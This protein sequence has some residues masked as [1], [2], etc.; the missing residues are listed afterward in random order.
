M[1]LEKGKNCFYKNSLPSSTT[2]SLFCFTM[3]TEKKFW[4]LL[5]VTSFIK[6]LYLSAPNL[7]PQ[8]AYYWSWTQFLDWSYFDHPPLATWSMVPFTRV[9]GD[10]VFWIRFPVWIYGILDAVAILWISRIVLKKTSPALWTLAIFNV[11]PLF[12]IGSI[13]MTPDVPLIFF[14]AATVYCF[15]RAL[16]EASLRSWVLTGVALGFA[17]LGKYSGILL[18]PSAL[19]FLALSPKD[20]HWLL[21]PQP[22]AGLLAAFVVFLPVVYWNASHEWVSLAFQSTRRAQ[23]MVS[24][25]PETVGQFLGGQIGVANPVLFCCFLFSMAYVSWKKLYVNDRSIALLYSFSVVPF[26]VCLFMSFFSFVKM[27]WPAPAYLTGFL[28][29]A[30]L[31]EQRINW[32][33][34]MLMGVGIG[35]LFAFMTLLLPARPIVPF[36]GDTWT[37]WPQLTQY[38]WDVKAKM[39]KEHGIPVFVFGNEYKVSVEMW[40][41]NPKQERTYSKNVLGEK[42]LQFD[43]YPSPD[44]LVGTNAVFVWWD[45]EPSHHSEL[46]ERHFR[47]VEKE[48]AFEVEFEGIVFQKYH[49]YRCYHYKGPMLPSPAS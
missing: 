34:W 12:L 30:H 5:A 37:G 22:Y 31:F 29:T 2:I 11:A 38:V 28:L 49:I 32:R 19:L 8:E 15:Y 46:L 33:R 23:G 39:E 35:V 27:N 20:R 43:Y 14:W 47:K 6:L 4:I 36:K 1:F 3:T 26:A 48:P 42:A 45:Q 41:H 44:S 16:D 17:M 7:V 13:V 25:R 24:L 9:F 21:K 10:S 40:F 18:I